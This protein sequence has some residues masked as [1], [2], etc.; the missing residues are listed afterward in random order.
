VIDLVFVF[1]GKLRQI[2]LELAIDLLKTLGFLLSHLFATLAHL[3]LLFL[4]SHHGC[5]TT[6]HV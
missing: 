5:L 3:L 1:R 4:L 2:V 6:V